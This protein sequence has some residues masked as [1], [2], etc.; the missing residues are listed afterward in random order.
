[1]PRMLD[2]SAYVE[3]TLDVKLADGN[4]IHL[5]KPTELLVVQMIRMREV[6]EKTDPLV[7]LA[8]L[9]KV[10]LNVLNNNADGLSFT[11][12][13]VAELP[14]DIKAGIVKGYTD[15]AVELQANPTTP[16]PAGPVK[17]EPRKKRNLLARWF[18]SRNTRG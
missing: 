17:P 14:M 18:R 10:A 5:K 9:N 4:V 1:M 7:V 8:T 16:S 6:D 12:Q 13:S 2:F 3:E 15:W 11:L